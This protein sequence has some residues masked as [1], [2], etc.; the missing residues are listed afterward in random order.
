MLKTILSSCLL[1]SLAHAASAQR[2]AARP[3]PKDVKGEGVTGTLQR[4][5]LFPSRRVLP[6]NVDVWL[7][8]G[9]GRGGR[10][11]VLYMHDGQNLFDPRTAYGGVDWG[12]DEAVTRLIGQGVVREAIVVGVWNTQ[13]RVAE[14]M[15][16]KA[17]HFSNTKDLKGVTVESADEIVSDEYL[18]F[19]VYELKPFIDSRYRTLRGRADTFIMG[20]SMGG[21]VSAY[22]A[23]EYPRVYGGA[24]CVSTHWPAGGGAMVEYL[25]T[26]LPDPRTHKFYFDYGTETLDAQYEPYQRRVDEI[27][28]RAGYAE[29]SSWVTR[30][31]EGEEHSEK[32][33]RKRVDIPLVFFLHK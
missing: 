22:A 8:P 3:E 30:K 21:L 28:E 23:C 9:Y 16:R 17:V 33:W 32:S 18:K 14:Y 25:K 4:Y 29:G 7:P 2:R 12:V 6:R 10:F 26:R 19:L 15:P 11:P 24:G 20:S 31:F 1:L 5:A 13:R 27:M